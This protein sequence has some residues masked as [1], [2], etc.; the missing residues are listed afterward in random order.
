[1]NKLENNHQDIIN[2]YIQFYEKMFEQC[3]EQLQNGKNLSK[4]LSE[5]YYR[6]IKIIN[7]F[8]IIDLS[9]IIF[10]IYVEKDNELKTEEN[11]LLKKIYL[12]IND[13]GEKISTIFL[14]NLFN[15]SKFK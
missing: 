11:L 2:K 12:G 5:Y 13:K 3:K 1:M 7:N 14:D 6:I 9:P 4:E 10:S 8:F 15:I